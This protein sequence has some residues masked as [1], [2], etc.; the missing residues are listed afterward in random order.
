MSDQPPELAAFTPRRTGAPLALEGIRVLDFT[1]MIAGPYC[2][3]MLADLGAEV[4]KIERPG[5]GD[6]TRRMAAVERGDASP[7]F[8]WAN[9][10]KKSVEL[11]LSDP[12][13]REMARALAAKADVVVENFTASVM[14][15]HGLDYDTLA[16]RNPRLIYV[17][18]SAFRRDGSA[19]GRA[20]YDPIVQAESGFMSMVGESDLPPMRVTPN[21]MDIATG[22]AAGNAALAALMARERHG[23]GQYVEASLFST[24][25][26]L[27]GHYSTKYLMTGHEQSRAG[28]RSTVAEPVGLAEAADGQVLITAANDASFRALV[29]GVLD[30]PE[31]LNHPDFATNVLRCK[32]EEKL[33][34]LL[35]PAIAQYTRADL[36]Q[37]AQDHRVPVASIRTVSEAL[38][39]EAA[40]AEQIIATTTVPETG[41]T[42]PNIASPLFMTETPVTDPIPA[43]RLGA[44]TISVLRDLI[45]LTDDELED[46]AN[47]GVIGSAAVS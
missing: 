24:A 31:V 14:K 47:A 9:R 30:L 23:I 35:R 37:R 40:R 13:G 27:L 18:I 5:T 44:H 43:P 42:I 45:G 17:A 28:H 8:Y 39:G 34:A 6:E 22:M 1:R 36:L 10:N 15:R 26:N 16:G 46:A 20:G 38:S 4:I 41:V 21:I 11:N 32:N 2:T 7:I 33:W 19:A 3:Q 25:I 12:R 29:G